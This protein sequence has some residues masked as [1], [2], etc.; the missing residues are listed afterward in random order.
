MW[1]KLG[2]R[3]LWPKYSWYRQ[4]ISIQN[5]YDC[6]FSEEQT[7]SLHIYRCNIMYLNINGDRSLLLLK[8]IY[9]LKLLCPQEQEEI[10]EWA[11]MCNGFS[12]KLG[13]KN[14]ISRFL[15]ELSAQI[16]PLKSANTSS[17]I[18]KFH[19]EFL[20]YEFVYLF[21]SILLITC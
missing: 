9:N 18:I 7:P 5:N 16:S 8:F 4:I 6:N 19:I 13:K 1:Q 11:V 12:I 14:L 10:Q 20:L 15:N 2:P 3:A 21:N 17:L